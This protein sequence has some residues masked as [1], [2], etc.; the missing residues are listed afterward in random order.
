MKVSDY[1]GMVPEVEGGLVHRGQVVQMHDVW[2]LLF[3]RE[4]LTPRG[5]LPCLY[6]R[7]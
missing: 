7:A 6:R 2:L 5:D 1:G 3:L 4:E